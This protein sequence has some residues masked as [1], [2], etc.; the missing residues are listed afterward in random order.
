MILV[1]W[2]LWWESDPMCQNLG[3]ISFIRFC[4]FESDL[5][6]WRSLT[7]LEPEICWAGKYS[8]LGEL[9]RGI[10]GSTWAL[11]TW[12]TWNQRKYLSTAITRNFSMNN[13]ES[14]TAMWA[15]LQKFRSKWGNPRTNVTS[16]LPI[17]ELVLFGRAWWMSYLTSS[18]VSDCKILNN[19]HDD[20]T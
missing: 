12:R 10:T 9:D 13:S 8:I 3:N 14:R 4:S 15:A 11:G 20:Y 2:T 16:H 19:Y 7:F 18:Q 6:S 1:H 17:I 5:C